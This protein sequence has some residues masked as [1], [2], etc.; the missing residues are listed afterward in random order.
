MVLPEFIRALPGLDMP[1]PEDVLTTH[2]LRSEDGLV[3]FFR[4][5][6][7]VD[8][9]PHSH[10]G[11]WGTV[12]EGWVELTIDGQTRRY[13]PGESYDIPSGTIHAVR[14]PAGAVLVDVFEEPDRYPL[15]R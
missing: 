2:A 8:L 4:I 15:K 9:P 1:F 7:E 3:V 6:Q 12:I 10:R 5:H 14:V 13:G 11:Q